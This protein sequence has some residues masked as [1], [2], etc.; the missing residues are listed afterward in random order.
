M[1][2]PTPTTEPQALRAGDTVA[3]LR[4]LSDYP[5]SAGW[6]LT[7][8]ILSPTA[9]AITLTAT[10]SGSDHA[11]AATAATTSGWPAGRRTW[12][13][14]VTKGSEAYTVAEG[15]L[16]ILPNPASL[17]THDGR[18]HAR[19]ML[20]AVEAALEG[21]ATASQLDVVE[22]EVNNRKM[23]YDRSALI[24]LRNLYKIETTREDTAAGRN[25]GRGRIMLR[26]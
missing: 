17:T 6:V 19:K 3:W 12:F 23:K 18:S 10:A 1:S 14:R 7:Y 20:D 22:W 4:S 25:R 2:T 15:T 13:A 8:T 5:A 16:D 21:S 24:K 26:M 9:A 11:V